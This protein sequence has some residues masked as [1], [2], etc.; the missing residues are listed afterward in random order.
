MR[1]RAAIRMVSLLA[2]IAAASTEPTFAQKSGGTTRIYH[3][4]TS[5]GASIRAATCWHPRVRGLTI[6]QNSLYNGWR[7]ED[8]WLER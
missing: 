4:D 3:R 1:R 2:L 7:F 6:M 8:I 5:P